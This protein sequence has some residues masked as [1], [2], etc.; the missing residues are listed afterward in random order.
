VLGTINSSSARV[1]HQTSL[2]RQAWDAT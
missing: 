1:P 2:R